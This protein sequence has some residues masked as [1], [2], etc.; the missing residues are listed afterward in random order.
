MRLLLIVNSSASSVTARRTVVIQ[1]ALSA[2][3]DV[4][5]VETNRRGHATR[6]A[7]DAAAKGID[8]VV[9]LGGDG[10]LNEVGQRPGRQRHGAGRAARRVDQ[11][12]R[13]HHRA[14]QRPDRGHRRAARR[15]RARVARTGRPRLGQ[16]PLLP[17]STP[18]WAST[19]PWSPRSNGTPRSS[20]G[21][22]TRCSSA[23][24]CG[25]GSA[26]TTAA[27]RTSGSTSTVRADVPAVRGV[28]A[29]GY[30]AVVLNTNPYTYLGNRPLDLSPAAGLDRRLVGHHASARCGPGPCSAPRPRRC[31][32]A[33]CATGPHRP[34][35]RTTTWRRSSSPATA[36]SRTR[37]T[38]T[39]WATP[40]RLALPPRAPTSS[41]WC[42]P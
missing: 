11:R 10:T 33:A 15:H 8:V 18:A 17:A 31:A 42:V 2:D 20:A 25:P 40:R 12:V 36:R 28:R 24:G 26:T 9:A 5:M 32:A 38:A 39:T 22:A 4:T 37:S 41:T 3:H 6:L 35:R 27:R 7:Q 13:P 29:D 19:P 16:R 1:K 34:R 23:P 14:A 30:F 21:P